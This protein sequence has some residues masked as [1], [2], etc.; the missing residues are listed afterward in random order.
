MSRTEGRTT[1]PNQESLVGIRDAAYWIFEVLYDVPDVQARVQARIDSMRPPR[2]EPEEA[3]DQLLDMAYPPVRF[4]TQEFKASA[5]LFGFDPDVYRELAG[6]LRA[7]Q[8]QA[9]TLNPTDQ[10]K[11]DYWKAFKQYVSQHA[12]ELSTP[13]AMAVHWMDFSV[14]WKRG[15]FLGARIN[16]R[17]NILTFGFYN[18]LPKAVFRY[19]YAQHEVIDEEVGESLDWDINADRKQSQAELRLAG[20]DIR[21]RQQWPIQFEWFV[22]QYRAFSAAFVP[23]VRGIDVDAITEADA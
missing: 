3:L 11:L 15:F 10:L 7:Q 19:L 21:D 14:F 1:V 16:T 12:P 20:I 22:K 4:G 6:E 23:R 17:Q 9:E 2:P 13:S 18:T 8:A 5:L